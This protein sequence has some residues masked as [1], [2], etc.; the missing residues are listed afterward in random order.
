MNGSFFGWL[1][2][3]ESVAQQHG[4]S[5][6]LVHAKPVAGGDAGGASAGGNDAGE[7]RGDDDGADAD[8]AVKTV[9][10]QWGAKLR[11]DFVP[12]TLRSCAFWAPMHV[13]N[14]LWVPPHFRVLFLSTGLVGWTAYLSIVGHR[15]GPETEEDGLAAPVSVVGSSAR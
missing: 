9:L 8:G 6:G 13:L 11:H 2:A 10:Y 12:T 3:W 7:V 14:F 5:T 4:L 15:G 1:I